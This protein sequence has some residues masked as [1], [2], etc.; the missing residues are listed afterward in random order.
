MK[1]TALILAIIMI[2]SLISCTNMPRTAQLQT[3]SAD[4]G[5]TLPGN[6]SSTDVTSLQTSSP[7]DSAGTLNPDFDPDA[8]R[9]LNEALEKLKFC[10]TFTYE[11]VV[12]KTYTDDGH[13]HNTRVIKKVS[14]ENFGKEDEKIRAYNLSTESSASK[15]TTKTEDIYCENGVSYYADETGVIYHTLSSYNVLKDAKPFK[16][17]REIT[18]DFGEAEVIADEKS[19]DNLIKI[20]LGTSSFFKTLTFEYDAKELD[21]TVTFSLN[22]EGL[23]T[24]GTLNFKQLLN[25]DDDKPENFDIATVE[26]IFSYTDVK[27]EAPEGYSDY[28]KSIKDHVNCYNK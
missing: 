14:V 9:L 18:G 19:G 17:L 7:A 4:T 28:I 26:V 24:K 16:T 27:A 21:Y 2:L 22:S 1:K 10:P 3:G 11:I 6:L 15:T 13:K 20:H 23:P 8:L 25:G 5:C 12:K